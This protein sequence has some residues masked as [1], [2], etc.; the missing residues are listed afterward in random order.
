MRN[1]SYFIDIRRLSPLDLS[2]YRDFLHQRRVP[3]EH[4]APYLLGLTGVPSSNR[5]DHPIT[6]LRLSRD[7]RVPTHHRAVAVCA[8]IKRIPYFKAYSPS[9]LNLWPIRVQAQNDRWYPQ[10]YVIFNS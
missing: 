3:G 4:K 8:D 1:E 2:S 5:N 9:L 6:V 10:L 7:S